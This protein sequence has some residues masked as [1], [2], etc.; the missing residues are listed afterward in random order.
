VQTTA[1]SAG[2]QQPQT[3]SPSHIFY[4][5]FLPIGGIA[6]IGIGPAG[7]RR[8]KLIQ[9]LLLCLALGAFLLAPAC[10]GSSNSTNK[11]SGTP[12]G[13]YTI[14]VSGTATVGSQ[15]GASPALTLTVN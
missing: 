11:S 2:L 6:L 15:T 13:T 10:G 1:A 12:A 7:T 4:A 8:K 3:N 14:T 9:G 5:M